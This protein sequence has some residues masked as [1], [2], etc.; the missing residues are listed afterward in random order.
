M[1]AESTERQRFE[2]KMFFR[3]MDLGVHAWKGWA[4]GLVLLLDEIKEATATELAAKLG[5][6]VVAL[7]GALQ[8]LREAGVAKR[9]ATIRPGTRSRSWSLT[10]DI[11][12]EVLAP[13]PPRT[14]PTLRERLAQ[15]A[16]DDSDMMR[17]FS[18]RTRRA[19]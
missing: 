3:L 14:G 16:D 7:Y 18:R 19:R 17:E 5:C 10:D 12:R 15:F 6:G 1:E 2:T 8:Q 4:C 13:I 9:S 11:G